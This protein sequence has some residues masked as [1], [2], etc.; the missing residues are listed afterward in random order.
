VYYI[1]G[2]EAHKNFIGVRYFKAFTQ[3]KSYMASPNGLVEC[4]ST[5]EVSQSVAGFVITRNNFFSDY[6]FTYGYPSGYGSTVRFVGG[7]K[8]TPFV[9]VGGNIKAKF[10]TTVNGVSYEMFCDLKYV[11]QK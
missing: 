3:L 4:P 7:N 8:N 10:S 2:R 6:S 5:F 9:A 11:E 1:A